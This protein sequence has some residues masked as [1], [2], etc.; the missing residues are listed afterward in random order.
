[1]NTKENVKKEYNELYKT[2]PTKWADT[3]RS[4]FMANAIKELMPAPKTIIDVGCGIGAALETMHIHF[5]E[6]DLYGLDPSEEAIALAK[7][8]VPDGTFYAEFLEDLKSKK[9]YD[10]V[11]CL[12]VAEHV[13]DLPEFLKSLKTLIKKDGILYFEVPHNLI[14]SRGPKTF[15]RLTVGSRQ[16]EWHLELR[17]WEKKLL[18]AGFEIVKRYRGLKSSWEFIWVLR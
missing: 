2:H 10:V 18:E 15:R 17:D 12:G 7:A 5:P 3:S 13:E 11:I 1:M 16:V 14:Y 9:K 4:V 8:R 6:A